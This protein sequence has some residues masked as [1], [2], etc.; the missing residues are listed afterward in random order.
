MREISGSHQFTTGKVERH[1]I[2]DI[3]ADILETA[4]TQLVLHLS[5]ILVRLLEILAGGLW[6]IDAVHGAR[7]S[8][9]QGECHLQAKA[10]VSAGDQR[11]AI[12]ERKLLGEERWCASR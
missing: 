2:S 11:D 12:G 10:A 6:E 4:F 9:N 1:L 7:T 3:R 5:R 8:L